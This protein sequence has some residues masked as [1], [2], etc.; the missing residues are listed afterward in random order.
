MKA[1]NKTKSMLSGFAREF[2][3]KLDV[4]GVKARYRTYDI[5]RADS[6]T[7]IEVR[8]H[9]DIYWAIRNFLRRNDRNDELLKFDNLRS[10]DGLESSH[11]DTLIRSVIAPLSVDKFLV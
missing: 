8:Y 2:E 11:M 1:S 10:A 9:W 7:N 6:V 3:D 4:A 5:P